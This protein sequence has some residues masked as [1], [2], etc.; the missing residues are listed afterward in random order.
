MN[1]ES[2]NY[3]IVIIIINIS[4]CC[5]KTNFK[6]YTNKNY[7]NYNYNNILI[8]IFNNKKE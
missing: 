7:Y 8:Y 4:F 2:N 6:Y 3:I 5:L 1:N